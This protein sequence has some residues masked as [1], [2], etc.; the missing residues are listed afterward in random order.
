MK[1]F[2]VTVT[3]TFAIEAPNE[4]IAQGRVDAVMDSFV[5]S[6]APRIL[7]A[8]WPDLEAPEIEIGEGE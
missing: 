5:A 1:T 4:K 8:W 6:K 2:P 3:I 7:P